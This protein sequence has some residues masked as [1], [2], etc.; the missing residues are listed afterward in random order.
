M[1]DD[2]DL[3][4]LVAQVGRGKKYASIHK[5]LIAHLVEDE[6]RHRGNVKEAIKATRRKLHQA[7]AVYMAGAQ[8]RYDRW[9]EGIQRA[10]ASGDQTELKSVCRSAMATH[11]SSRERLPILDRFYQEVLG[12]LAPVPS[13]IDLAC[14]LNPLAIPWMPLASGAEY[15][16][17]DIFEDLMHFLG[18]ALPL[19]GVR[20]D[21][22]AVDLTGEI[23]I[24]SAKV[25]LLLKT[26]P[27]LEQLDRTA[28]ARLLDTVPA[29]YLVVS[30][31]VQSLGGR[32]D[33]GMPEHYRAHFETL[34][35][36]KPWPIR[37]WSYESELVYLVDKG[38]KAENDGG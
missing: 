13:V 21:A 12:D 27:C 33:R 20:S 6:F 10:A 32:R 28:G 11:Q 14:G 8:Q 1:S 16:A 15:R 4:Q 36:G 3:Q 30:Y 22:R 24:P 38:D 7:G 35:A 26:I 17:C 2:A 37:S 31:P 25:A 18:A 29:R 19:L 23:S 9:L 5:G 34:T